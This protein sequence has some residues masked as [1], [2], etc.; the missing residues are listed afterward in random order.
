MPG[1]TPRGSQGYSQRSHVNR[2]GGRRPIR[3]ESAT[4]RKQRQRKLESRASK[5][6]VYAVK[7]YIDT[8]LDRV[9]WITRLK[10]AA[11]PYL[12]KAMM[13]ETRKGEPC[14]AVRHHGGGSVVI[15]RVCGVHVPSGGTRLRRPLT[16][17]QIMKVV[18]QMHKPTDGRPPIG[19]TQYV[20]LPCNEVFQVP[21]AMCLKEGIVW[22]GDSRFPLPLM[23]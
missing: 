8:R 1:T 14:I 19:A 2:G 7:E 22:T 18:L 20:A 21:L 11:R 10:N 15:G 6:W 5:K 12:P 4:Q 9:K 17:F 3:G 13:P 16:V 23:K